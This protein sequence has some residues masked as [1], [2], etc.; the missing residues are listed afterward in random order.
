MTQTFTASMARFSF[1]PVDTVDTSHINNISVSNTQMKGEFKKK[2][3][4]LLLKLSFHFIAYFDF[5]RIPAVFESSTKRICTKYYWRWQLLPRWLRL[6]DFRPRE[7][8]KLRT[9]PGTHNVRSYTATITTSLLQYVDECIQGCVPCCMRIFL[10]DPHERGKGGEARR[11]VSWCG[12]GC[13]G[14]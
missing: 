12:R 4:K 1:G 13:C 10:R 7:I 6:V 3:P 14:C 5:T 9:L 11:A 8:D 2:I